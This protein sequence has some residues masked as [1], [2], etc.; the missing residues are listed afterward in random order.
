[1]CTMVLCVSCP[2]GTWAVLPAVHSMFCALVTA[3]VFLSRYYTCYYI[4]VFFQ[5]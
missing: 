4:L 1:M 5:C 3:L 2:V